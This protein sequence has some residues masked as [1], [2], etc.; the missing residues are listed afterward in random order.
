M[1]S[2]VCQTSFLAIHGRF[3]VFMCFFVSCWVIVKFLSFMVYQCY[4]L[5]EGKPSSIGT[6]NFRI[7]FRDVENLFKYIYIVFILV[8]HYVT[9]IFT[10]Q[11]LLNITFCRTCTSFNKLNNLFLNLNMFMCYKVEQEW[12]RAKCNQ[13]NKTKHQYF[14]TLF[15]QF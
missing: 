15:S 13:T 8:I 3:V 4:P 6:S 2:P 9:Y 12:K 5:L 7:L 10:S 14:Q 1:P 11:S